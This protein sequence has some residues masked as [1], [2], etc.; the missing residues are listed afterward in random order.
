MGSTPWWSRPHSEPSRRDAGRAA[1]RASA[2]LGDTDR[3]RCL[4]RP[5]WQRTIEAYRARV[6]AG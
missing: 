2:L 5:V 1:A 6:E 4:A 3:D